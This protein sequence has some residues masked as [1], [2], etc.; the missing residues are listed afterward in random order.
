MSIASLKAALQRIPVPMLG[1][2][3]ADY[4]QLVELITAIEER[5]EAI[6]PG[7]EEP[8]GAVDGT[9]GLDLTL[10]PYSADNAGVSDCSSILEQAIEDG[11]RSIWFPAGRYRFATAVSIPGGISLHGSNDGAVVI[12]AEDEYWVEL[13]TTTR[14]W[15]RPGVG[16][17]SITSR[18]RWAAAASARTATATP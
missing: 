15:T 4:D 18:S 6:D 13:L 7:G 16:A 9:P 1:H 5:F 14:R 11:F 12:E 2:E 8:V 17:R 3:M 10:P